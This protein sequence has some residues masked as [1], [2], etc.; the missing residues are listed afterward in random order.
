LASYLAVLHPKFNL[1]VSAGLERVMSFSCFIKL[2]GAAIAVAIIGYII[3]SVA[4]TET[5]PVPLLFPTGLL[6]GCILGGVLVVIAPVLLKEVREDEVS[7]IYVGN[8]PF[9]AGESD[10]RNL[11]APYGEV[12]EVRLVKDRRSRRPKGYAFVEMSVS[13]ARS[14]IKHLNDTDYAGRTLRVNEGKKKEES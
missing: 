9:N 3:G 13:D 5:V 4:G 8:L 6:I 11:F 1:H 2:L 14:A 10:I 7:S 12:I